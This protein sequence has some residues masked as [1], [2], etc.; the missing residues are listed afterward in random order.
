[1]QGRLLQHTEHNKKALQWLQRNATQ[2]SVNEKGEV[3]RSVYGSCLL[4][5]KGIKAKISVLVWKCIKTSWKMYT[6]IR[7]YLCFLIMCLVSTI[8]PPREKEKQQNFDELNCKLTLITPTGPWKELYLACRGWVPQQQYHNFLP[9]PF[10]FYYFRKMGCVY[11]CT[12]ISSGVGECLNY[13][14][15]LSVQFI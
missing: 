6:L 3:Q 7:D 8:H 4:C 11:V 15:I 9:F 5:T 14:M 10:R 2:D 13:I 1:M 12:H